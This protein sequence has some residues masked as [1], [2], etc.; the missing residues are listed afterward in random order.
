M[1][2]NPRTRDCMVFR[3]CSRCGHGRPRTDFSRDRR[4]KDGLSPTCVSCD[5]YRYQHEK[6]DLVSRKAPR[7]KIPP[8]NVSKDTGASK[9]CTRCGQ[10]KRLCDFGP[11]KLGKFGLKAR[12]RECSSAYVGNKAKERQV[13]LDALK[14]KPCAD[15]GRCLPPCCMDLDHVRGVKHHQVSDMLTCTW[16]RFLGE[17]GKCDVVCGCCHRVRSLATWGKTVSPKLAEFHVKL[18]VLKSSP[19][20]DCGR[21]YPPEAMDF[22]HVRGTKFRM[23]STMV[24]YA[25][26]RVL[27][28]VS[29]C[30]LVCACCHRLRTHAR[31][32]GGQIIA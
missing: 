22:D 19:C 28:E 25:W 1:P 16:D 32:K 8:P 30:D 6:P 10:T 21:C 24:S 11:S 4:S 2:E 5:I 7:K 15:C 14:S 27:L 29:K 23:V 20:V 9:V 17:V 3:T 13:V 18:N 26:G 12:C 31:Q